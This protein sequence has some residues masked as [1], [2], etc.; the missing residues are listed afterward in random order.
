MVCEDLIARTSQFVFKATNSRWCITFKT[1]SLISTVS[2][3]LLHSVTS[4]NVSYNLPLCMSQMYQVISL[5][6]HVCDVASCTSQSLQLLFFPQVASYLSLCFIIKLISWSLNKSMGE[7]VLCK[8]ITSLWPCKIPH[9]QRIN[10]QK[11][12]ISTP[13]FVVYY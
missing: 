10:P 3:T 5:Q 11:S 7:K 4:Y 2:L 9:Q 1:T 6:T 13:K 8:S 12:F